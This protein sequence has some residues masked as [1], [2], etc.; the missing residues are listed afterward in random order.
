MSI[1]HIVDIFTTEA[2]RTQRGISTC[3]EYVGEHLNFAKIIDCH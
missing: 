1:I 2:I 3:V